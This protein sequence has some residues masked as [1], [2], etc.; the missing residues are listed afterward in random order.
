MLQNGSSASWGGGVDGL[1]GPAGNLRLR[2]GVLKE[3]KEDRTEAGK[4][5]ASAA[6]GQARTRHADACGLVA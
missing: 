4:G 6:P 5:N 1:T 2:E 3:G